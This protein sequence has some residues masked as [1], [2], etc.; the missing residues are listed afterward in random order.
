VVGLALV[1]R[2]AQRGQFVLGG[3]DRADLVEVDAHDRLEL[4]DAHDARDLVVAVAARAARARLGADEAALLVV[5][6][7]PTRDAEIAGNFADR[8][9][10]VAHTSSISS[11]TSTAISSACTYLPPRSHDAAAAMMHMISDAVNAMR[12]PWIK[13]PEMSCGKNALPVRCAA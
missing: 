10:G 1:P 4:A 2:G 3:E 7:R 8:R 12:R 6:Q 5:T 11:A 9:V 13:G